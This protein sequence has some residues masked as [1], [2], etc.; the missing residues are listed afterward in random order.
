MPRVAHRQS[1]SRLIDHIWQRILKRVLLIGLVCLF[2]IYTLLLPF[3]KHASQVLAAPTAPCATP[4]KDGPGGAMAGIVNTYYPPPSAT[5]SV[6]S[7]ATSLQV[8]SP[9]GASTP[10]SVGD[11]LL[12]IQMQ[13]A[14]INSTNTA[15]YGDGVGGDVLAYPTVPSSTAASGVV[16]TTAG[17]YEYVTV[18]SVSGST[19][20]I[21]GTGTGG[22]L[23]NSY[24]NSAATS[25][26]GQSTYQ[27]VRVPQYS[28]ATLGNATALAWNGSV[29]GI[30]AYDVAGNLNLAGTVDVSGQGFRG[31]G[32]RRLGGASGY[33]NTDYRTPATATANGSK[34]EGIAGTPRYIAQFTG[35]GA[36]TILDTGAEGYPNGSYGRGAPGT[37]GGGS[38][39]GN[40]GSNDQNS[41]GGGGANGGNGGI[42]GR[43]WSS[44]VP[45]G[46]FGGKAF[47]AATDRL[48]LGGG[49][50]AGT[51]NDGS[52]Y[53]GTAQIGGNGSYSSGAPGGGM[54]MVRTNT[55]SGTGTIL[56][57]GSTP[58]DVGQDGG[59]GGG[60]GG[61]VF[62]STRPS[63]GNS[64]A[65][66]TVNVQGGNGG[67]ARFS[68]AHGP[69]G[70]GGGG[71]VINSLPGVSIGSLAGGV[72]GRTG[73]TGNLGNFDAAA[74]TGLVQP[75]TAGI[76]PGIKSGAEC[77]ADL[78]VEKS[79][80]TRTIVS[81]STGG[82]TATYTITVSNAANRAA[83]TQVTVSD[84]GLP[85]GFTYASTSS[86][87]LTGGAVQTSVSNPT[88]GST[89]P[90]WGVFT[91][92][93]GGQVQITFITAIATTVTA[94]TYQ[95]PAIAQYLDPV[96]TTTNGTTTAT[97]DI[98]RPD[99]DVM[100][101]IGSPKLLLVKRITR[102]NS[103]DI[104][105]VVDDPNTTDDN[106]PNWV[107]STFLRGAIDGGTIKPGDELEY[108][109]Y[110]LSA[111]DTTANNVWLCDRVPDNTTFSSTAFN[112]FPTQAAGGLPSG[113][114]GMQWLYNGQTES[115]TNVG[116]G[117]VAQYFPAGNNPISPFPS[118]NCGGT[119]T[120]GAIVVNLGNLSHTTAPGIPA[121]SYGFVRFRGRVR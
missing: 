30:L 72:G 106:D 59:G 20:G 65:G 42:G 112:G 4:G 94:G 91:I 68:S 18:T 2:P 86:I 11:L 40:P 33:S 103:T 45:S 80:S 74:G 44:Q 55:V 83:A 111:G 109:I 64:L 81:P 77:T 14:A 71:V 92:P 70:G 34:G 85:S 19:I 99:E 29:G 62:V 38:T 84:P 82:K 31:G 28:S 24:I 32:A 78:I 47:S 100:I 39:D 10:I 16:S 41:G 54:V 12:I 52:F 46:G 90:S 56:A 22:G 50:G 98:N 75:L 116:D 3:D 105:T 107:N 27:I 88:V 121:N 43:A 119:N 67:W 8:G 79:T 36:P 26:K 95:N 117:D 97:Y 120:N 13:D 76:V 17:Q 104:T 60:A 21:A 57:Q 49:G 6:S 87:A 7:G 9:S 37:A 66:L 73:A 48:V 115:L 51:T 35:T 118:V 5:A 114:R 15:A 113:D 108:T 102:I 89:S 93:G 53:T 101:T 25:T 63:S 1:K 23:L 58:R 61:T 96:R 69:G 110:Y